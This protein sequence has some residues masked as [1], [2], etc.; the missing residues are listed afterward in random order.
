MGRV[1]EPANYSVVIPG[2]SGNERELGIHN[3]CL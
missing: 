1:I 3:Y 2:P